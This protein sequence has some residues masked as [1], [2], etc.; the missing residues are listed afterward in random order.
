M[1]THLAKGKAALLSLQLEDFLEMEHPGNVPGTSDEYRNW[2]RKLSQN[3]EQL[4]SNEQIKT[5]LE[6][7]TIARKE[8]SKNN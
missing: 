8:A 5:L 4:F 7:L 6:N 1:Q 2:Q 3:I